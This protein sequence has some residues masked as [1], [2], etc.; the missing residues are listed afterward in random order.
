[1]LR[2][3]LAAQ[4]VQFPELAKL[5]HEE[6]WLRG[7][8]PKRNPLLQRFADRGQI[9]IGVDFAMA[10]STCSS[11]LCSPTNTTAS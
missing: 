11:V 6:G 5:A 7:F 9:E 1:M 2:R 4:A 3:T 8:G 10:V